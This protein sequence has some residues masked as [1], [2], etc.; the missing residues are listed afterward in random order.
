M[1]GQTV[2]CDPWYQDSFPAS[3]WPRKIKSILRE[4]QVADDPESIDDDERAMFE[5][6]GISIETRV[7]SDDWKEIEVWID[8]SRQEDT[9]SEYQ[10]YLRLHPNT[11]AQQ[12][13]SR[14]VAAKAA[15]TRAEGT[16]ALASKS[17]GIS[18]HRVLD[19]RSRDREGDMCR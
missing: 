18:T 10:E 16:S 13:T 4:T 1:P 5:R 15:E 12:R 9:I 7:F 6:A 17:A 8:A 3:E 19:A 11:V 2:F 14:V